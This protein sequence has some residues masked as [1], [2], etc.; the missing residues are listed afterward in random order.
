MEVLPPLAAGPVTPLRPVV[1][2]FQIH[3]PVQV[4]L[5]P[6][7]HVEPFGPLERVQV[8]V[9]LSHVHEKV[10]VTFLD[11]VAEAGWFVHSESI[12]IAQAMRASHTGSIVRIWPPTFPSISRASFPRPLIAQDSTQPEARVNRGSTECPQHQIVGVLLATSRRP[13][14]LAARRDA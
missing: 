12:K 2:V 3:F 13:S 7:V 1:V 6:L 10:P 8:P 9:P 14:A 4:P 5:T 11:E